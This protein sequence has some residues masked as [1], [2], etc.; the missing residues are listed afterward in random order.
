M[1]GRALAF[2]FIGRTPLG[3]AIRAAFFG[4]LADFVGSLIFATRWQIFLFA[5]AA[6]LAILPVL[7]I[8]AGWI[9]RRRRRAERDESLTIDE[10]GEGI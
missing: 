5:A 8:V 1:L 9:E 7:Y 3:I 10:P 6:I 4:V 2:L